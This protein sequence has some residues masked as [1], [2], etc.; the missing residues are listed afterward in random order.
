MQAGAKTLAKV[1]QRIGALEQQPAAAAVGACPAPGDR[2]G[3]PWITGAE[4]VGQR[5]WL[6]QMLTARQGG[7]VCP[8]LF[9]FGKQRRQLCQCRF[10]EL[11]IGGQFAA[12]YREQRSLTSAIAER[13]RVVAGDRRGL[14]GLVIAKRSDPSIAVA[15]I[16]AT[17]LMLEVRVDD[18]QQVVDFFVGDL[19]PRRVAVVLMVGGAD[20]AELAEVR[21]D[22][23]DAPVL[24]LQ[25]VGVLTFIEFRH[26]DMAALDQAH[27]VRGCL[28]ELLFDER[29]HPRAGGVDQGACADRKAAAILTFQ[30]QVPER[31][32]AARTDAASAGVDMGPQ[33]ACRHGIENHQPGVID[34]AIGVLETMGDFVLERAVG[35]ETQTARTAE[36]LALA[37]VIVKKQADTD[38]PRRPQVRA[39]GQHEA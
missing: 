35:T 24:V 4:R 37:E 15:D 2:T 14:V 22:E 12:E 29:G 33:L 20:Q 18:G 27:A 16:G 30:M 23:H 26:D 21:R 17:Q 8:G 25:D 7:V 10:G 31:F 9:H 38:H 6:V 34:P 5:R 3:Q 19:H 36:L 11:A 1:L 32:A 28:P 39:V 13:Q